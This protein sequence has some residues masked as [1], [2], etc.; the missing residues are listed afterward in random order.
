VRIPI[1]GWVTTKPEDVKKMKEVGYAIGGLIALIVG[2]CLGLYPIF[3]GLIYAELGKDIFLVVAASITAL[4]C[5]AQV[6]EE[7][8]T[9]PVVLFLRW[10]AVTLLGF[11]L[12]AFFGVLVPAYLM[13]PAASAITASTP[14]TGAGM[15]ST[16]ATGIGGFFAAFLSPPLL[17]SLLVVA[18]LGAAAAGGYYYLKNK[19]AAARWSPEVRRAPVR[20]YSEPNIKNLNNHLE[21]TDN[22]ERKRPAFDAEDVKH[23]PLKTHQ[24]LPPHQKIPRSTSLPDLKKAADKPS[25]SNPTGNFPLKP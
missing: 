6:S 8:L 14:A 19:P 4:F 22:S 18:C 5:S 16:I 1:L 10:S 24:G 17:I 20:R 12:L 23:V 11:G 3:F 7:G 21:L 15:V 2:T 25:S 9:M 13:H